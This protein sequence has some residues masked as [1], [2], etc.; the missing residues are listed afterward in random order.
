[1]QPGTA[2][3][4]ERDMTALRD[5]PRASPAGAPDTMQLSIL[6]RSCDSYGGHPLH[7]EIVER[8]RAAGLPGASVFRGVQGFGGSGAMHSAG[9]AGIRDG[10][11]VMVQIV[12]GA[13]QVEAFLP[14]LG[15][16]MGSGLVMV[17]HVFAQRQPARTY[18][19]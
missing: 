9:W 7:T 16:L 4:A 5:E 3:A 2:V 6:V 11:P 10:L 12:G 18:Q 13:A 19:P 14:V 8:A 15:S 1:V 17:S